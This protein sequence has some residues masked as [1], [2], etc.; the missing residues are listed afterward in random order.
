MSPDEARAPS[1]QN[2]HHCPSRKE[3][4]TRHPPTLTLPSWVLPSVHCNQI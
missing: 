1:E 4:S 2:L 3:L